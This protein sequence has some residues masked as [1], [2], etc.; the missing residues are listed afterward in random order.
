MPT[1]CSLM[2]EFTI[3]YNPSGPVAEPQIA[4]LVIDQEDNWK[5]TYKISGRT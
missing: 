1:S 2:Q 5:W 3:R 4:T